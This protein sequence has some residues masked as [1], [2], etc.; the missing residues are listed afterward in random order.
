[1]ATHVALVSNSISFQYFES[2]AFLNLASAFGVQVSIMGEIKRSYEA[3]KVV[4]NTGDEQEPVV[5]YK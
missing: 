2:P 4:I 3:A 1:M 5:E